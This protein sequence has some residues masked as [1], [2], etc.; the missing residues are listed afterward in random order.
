MFTDQTIVKAIREGGAKREKALKHLFLSKEYLNI[1]GKVVA[2]GGGEEVMALQIFEDCLILFDKEVRMLTWKEGGTILMAFE[3][4]AKRLW[5]EKLTESEI[6]QKKVL[7]EISVDRK[8][9]NEI[10]AKITANSGRWEDA[11]DCYQNGMLLLHTQLREG[12]YK[13]GAVKGYFYQICYNL[14]RNELKRQKN[15]SLEEEVIYHQS[16]DD[17][18]R[19]LEEKEHRELL[20]RVFNMLGESCRKILHLKYF[21]VEQLSMDEIA[22]QMG[23]KNAQNASNTLSKCRNRLW[24]L[25]QEAKQEIYS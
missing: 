7:H 24:D 3:L 9:K 13:G 19:M 1:V 8:L 17:P 4:N 25:L 22:Q 15:Y 11:E 10:L 14:W 18:G 23:L 16:S 20:N 6:L 12:K 21:M 5:S 2:D